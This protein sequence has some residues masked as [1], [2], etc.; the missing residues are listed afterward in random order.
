MIGVLIGFYAATGIVLGGISG[1]AVTAIF[2]RIGTGI[3]NNS[4]RLHQVA[5]TLVLILVFAGNQLIEFPRGNSEIVALI[6]G[7]LLASGL[8]LTARSRQTSRA[9]VFSL[10]IRGPSACCC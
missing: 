2:Q 10:A 4:W 7:L 1:L 8:M 9:V 3:H 6:L 5:A